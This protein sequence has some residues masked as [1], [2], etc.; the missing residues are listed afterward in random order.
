MSEIQGAIGIEQL[1]KLNKI[2]RYQVKLANMFKKN[3]NIK[4]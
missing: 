4:K 1:K 2:I 3:L